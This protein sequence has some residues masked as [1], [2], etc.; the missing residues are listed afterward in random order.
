MKGHNTG[1]KLRKTKDNCLH[2]GLIYIKVYTIC[3]QNSIIDTEA[4]DEKYN[5]HIYEG[6][7]ICNEIVPIN[8]KVLYLYALQ[9]H[10]TNNLLLGYIT[11][12]SQV[13]SSF[14][15]LRNPL[16]R[17]GTKLHCDTNLN[18]V[19]K[20]RILHELSVFSVFLFVW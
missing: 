1:Q 6:D 13:S 4:E 8:Q 9:L 7:S 11:A 19:F 5:F 18:S 2:L 14:P 3:T 12:K 20:F 17:K 16:S 10:S 15:A